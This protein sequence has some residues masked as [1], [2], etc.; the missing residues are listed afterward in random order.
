MFL[1]LNGCII[2]A[3]QFS[4]GI[5]FSGVGTQRVVHI[6]IDKK[7]NQYAV[8]VYDSTFAIDSISVPVMIR[9]PDRQ[10]L[11]EIL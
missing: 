1:I 4:N 3:Q 11:I 2:K 8:V 6:S 7:G 5:L 9:Q 10:N